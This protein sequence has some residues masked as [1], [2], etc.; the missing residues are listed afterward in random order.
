MAEEGAIDFVTGDYKSTTILDGANQ[1]LERRSIGGV[2]YSSRG[3][4]R[5]TV[6]YAVPVQK[7]I[8]GGFASE[9]EAFTDPP[10]A[11]R[12]LAHISAPV[13]RVG[14]RKEGGVP[15][16]VYRLST[17]LAAF[18]RAG[19]GHLQDPAAYR[20]VHATLEASIDHEGR[21]RRVDETFGSG[22]TT[23]RT[24]VRFGGYGQVVRVRPPA[25]S[26]VRRTKGPI[27]PNP[28]GAGPGSLLAPLLFLRPGAAGH[29]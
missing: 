4:A 20:S 3:P 10:A 23:L 28:L 25:S 7:G 18:L 19:G 15:T 27:R 22:S 12:A 29:S 17:N 11:F 21:P 24:V 6:W 13:R 16:V 14:M 1:R 2:L 9:S 5:K 26:L 8:P